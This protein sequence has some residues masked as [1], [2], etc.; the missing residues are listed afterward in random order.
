MENTDENKKIS[1]FL[2]IAG[3]IIVELMS[4]ILKL[5]GLEPTR[6]GTGLNTSFKVRNPVNDTEMTFCLHNL[7]LEIATVDRDEEPLRFDDRL[8]DFRLFLSKSIHVINSKLEVLFRLAGGSDIDEAIGRIEDLVGKYERIRI[9]R[10]D[11][12]SPRNNGIH[13]KEPDDGQDE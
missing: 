8:K 12:N 5:N 7:L 1:R 10:I 4:Q 2:N 11:Q 13:G 3:P 6:A 9:L